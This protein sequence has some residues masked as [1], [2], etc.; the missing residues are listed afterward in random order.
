MFWSS[1]NTIECFLGHMINEYSILSHLCPHLQ[2]HL[3]LVKIDY[4]T[5]YCLANYVAREFLAWKLSVSSFHSLVTCSIFNKLEWYLSNRPIGGN[6]KRGCPRTGFETG[7]CKAALWG[8]F[9]GKFVSKNSIQ[10][11]FLGVWGG[12]GGAKFQKCRKF[13]YYSPIWYI[14]SL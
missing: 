9:W 12:G 3:E 8:K 1:R 10:G 11:E 13:E 14:I 2:F 5:K 7:F 6:S 4:V